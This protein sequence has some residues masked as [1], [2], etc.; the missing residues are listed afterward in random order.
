MYIVVTPKL[1]AVCRWMCT[2]KGIEVLYL[3]LEDIV[4]GNMSSRVMFSVN[5]DIYALEIISEGDL[6]LV[7]E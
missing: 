6:L 3:V 1:E 2:I 5:H 7:N 4:C